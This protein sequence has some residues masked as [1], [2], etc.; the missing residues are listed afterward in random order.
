MSRQ[1]DTVGVVTCHDA[2]MRKTTLGW[3]QSV[4]DAVFAVVLDFAH[5]HFCRM[6]HVN[7]HGIA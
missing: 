7:S 1:C 5:S 3:M 6:A 4:A 2:M